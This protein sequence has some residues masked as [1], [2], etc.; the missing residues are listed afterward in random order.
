VNQRGDGI[1]LGYYVTGENWVYNNLII[2]AGLGPE[3]PDDVSYHTGI[4]I[5]TGHETSTTTTVY[6]YNNTLYGCGWSGAMEGASGHLLVSPEALALRTNLDFKNNIIYS[7]GE[8][9]LAGESAA[10]PAGDYRNC[11][12]GNGI[13]PSW[14]SRA[15]NS[16]PQFV[17]IGAK[18][19]QLKDGGP[20]INAGITVSSVVT[21][22]ILGVPRPQGSAFDLGVYEYENP[23]AVTVNDPSGFMNEFILQQNYPNPFNATTHIEYRVPSVKSR[24][25][26]FV[27]LKLYDMLGREVATLVNEEQPSGSY[28]L[29]FDTSPLGSGVYFYRLRVG[30]FSETKKMSL[31]K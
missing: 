16:D 15:I 28:S 8:P 31:V 5:N 27:T 1:L 29:N 24:L 13:S 20:C 30:G 21:R 12:F 14:D 10:L 23:S 22:D 26:P 17:N 6:C 11:W 19:F 25:S 2:N 9:Y 18:N 4:R 7:T 3:W